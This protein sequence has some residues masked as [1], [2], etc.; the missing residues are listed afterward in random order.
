MIAQ[1]RLEETDAKAGRAPKCQPAAVGFH[2]AVIP[3]RHSSFP[4]EAF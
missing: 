4:A 3:I 1:L 2:P